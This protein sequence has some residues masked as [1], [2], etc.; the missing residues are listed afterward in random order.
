MNERTKE[1]KNEGTQERK[2]N[3]REG[4]KKRRS[5]EGAKWLK[6]WNEEKKTH[7]KVKEQ[8]R[9]RRNEKTRNGGTK[10]AIKEGR[11]KERGRKERNDKG[12][13]REF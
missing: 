10:A 5:N 1:R 4:T 2:P 7:I 12:S 6:L 3:E 9:R 13:K 8:I 11:K